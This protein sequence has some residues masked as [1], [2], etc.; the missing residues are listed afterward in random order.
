MRCVIFD[1]DGTLVDTAGDLIA[2]G[3][4][5]FQTLGYGDVLDLHQDAIVAGQGVRKLMA[6]GF[7]RVKPDF[8]EADIDASHGLVVAYY[9]DNIAV[10]S[11]L[12][13][14][15]VAAIEGLKRDGYAVGVCTNKP[16]G[17]AELLL[18]K[19][20]V[21]DL[22]GALVGSDTMSERKPHPM[23]YAAAVARA[24]GDLAQS[25][26]VGDTITDRKTATAANV[27]SALVSFGPI[28]QDVLQYAPDAV[29]DH[30]DDLARITQELIG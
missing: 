12:Y 24:G 17:L 6:A 5:Q 27:P 20:G 18:G 10:H 11:T 3:N 1:L 29:L 2:A 9:R 14:G 8:D 30:Y 23:P 13:D 16:E 22:F 25:Y 28:G 4:H 26:L 15:A 19:L 7:A 21:R